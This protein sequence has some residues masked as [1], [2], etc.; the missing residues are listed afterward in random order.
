M[1]QTT[2]IPTMLTSGEDFKV[3][4]FGGKASSLSRL[5][6]AGFAVP[7][8]FGIPCSATFT[9]PTIDFSNI[10]YYIDAPAKFAV[11]SGAPISMPG[12]LST[13]L[14]VPFEELQQAVEAVW[15]S[16]STPHA[17]AY[18]EAKGIDHSMGT[19][20]II[21]KQ[22]DAAYAGVAFTCD[23]NEPILKLYNPQIEYVE[24]LGESLVG[25][26]VTPQKL[27]SNEAVAYGS[28]KDRLLSR[29]KEAHD[30]F[31]P[32]D[33]EWCVE[34]RWSSYYGIHVPTLYFVQQRALRFA[35][36]SDA[37]K[38]AS[39]GKVLF[40][41]LSIGSPVRVT[42]KVT[43]D[44]TQA[45]GN[46]IYAKDFTPE[47]YEPM[48]KSAG[49]I[50]AVGGT[51]CHAS[52]IARELGK[53]ALSGVDL[54]NLKHQ[55]MVLTLDGVDGTLR[56]AFEED[57]KKNRVR[58]IVPVRDPERTPDFS[59]TTA[60]YRATDL[61]IRVYDHVQMEKDGEITRDRLNEVVSEV[62]LLFGTYLYQAIVGEVRHTKGKVRFE[63]R[64][65]KV[66]TYSL[67][68]RL[69]KFGVMVPGLAD[70]EAGNRVMFTSK[71]VPQPQSLDQTISVMK[72]CKHI[73]N[74][75]W[76]GS[77]GGKKWAKITDIALQYFTGE[78]SP[79]LFV[80]AV[81]NLSHN[82]GSVF[83]K[84]NWMQA[85]RTALQMQLDYKR[86]GNQTGYR[87]YIHDHDI[88][89]AQYLLKR[90]QAQTATAA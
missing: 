58:R 34:N 60:E 31:G 80:D 53:P 48:V 72:L 23:P 22:I 40:T 7:P 37:D 66:R 68:G 39:R 44:L 38:Q 49:I 84:Y 10:P 85:N 18:R 21:Q 28:W 63:N 61:L 24:G 73:F 6:L 25:G 81:F 33:L 30:L 17:V 76:L 9:R 55:D 87:S 78:L 20:V 43:T 59:L 2:L 82:S 26:T 79:M 64:R 35:A 13:K 77:Y 1:S 69:R 74:L 46:L 29:V 83:G 4:E 65:D 75:N 3:E 52:I 32:S 19:G 27:T 8:A 57:A 90:P 62:A 50:C 88:P 70:P 71:Y 86:I 51:T 11:R 67:I 14:N 36:I 41:G 89:K 45:H 54:D 15:D 5:V 42:G 12:L 16:W 47:M 56:L